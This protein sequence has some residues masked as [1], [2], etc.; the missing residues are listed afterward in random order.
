MRTHPCIPMSLLAGLL[1]AVPAGAAPAAS[2]TQSIVHL[3]VQLAGRPRAEV[4]SGMARA[5][6]PFVCDLFSAPPAL[7]DASDLK[8][9]Y[10]ASG[11]WTYTSLSFAHIY[12]HPTFHALERRIAQTYGAPARIEPSHFGGGP[13]ADV[14]YVARGRVAVRLAREW[15]SKAIKIRIFARSQ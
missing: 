6:L 2:P 13:E 12:G 1:A 11:R 5:G 10:S 9:C 8:V 4:D 14:W 3:A 7:R 15:P